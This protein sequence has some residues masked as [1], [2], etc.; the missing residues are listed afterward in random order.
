[1]QAMI[2]NKPKDDFY[3]K[4]ENLYITSPGSYTIIKKVKNP[5]FPLTYKKVV[6]LEEKWLSTP[7]IDQ[8]GKQAEYKY[9]DKVLVETGEVEEE[10]IIPEEPTSEE[11]RQMII[12]DFTEA[13][14]ENDGTGN[15][16]EV[17]LG[18]F[19]GRRFKVKSGYL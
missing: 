5:I 13:E 2:I 12:R 17:E 4:K 9:K 1:M 14:E 7:Y 8:D 18:L 6:K 15:Q 19:P 3:S 10:E 11:I 16:C